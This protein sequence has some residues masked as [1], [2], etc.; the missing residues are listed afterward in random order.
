MEIKESIIVLGASGGIGQALCAQLKKQG[1]QLVV[2]ARNADRLSELASK[3]EVPYLAGDAR[4]LSYVEELA[5]LAQKTY[6]SIT[7]AVNLAGSLLLKPAHT[8]TEEEWK[9]TLETNLTTSFYL[10][11]T[12]AAAMRRAGGSIVLMSSVAARLGLS[13]HEAIAAAKAG[14]EGL[15]ISAAAT[16]SPYKVRVN[17]VA[18]GLIKTPLTEKITQHE[19]S[20]KASL[21][22]HPLNRL[23]EPEDV[24]SAIAWLLNPQQSWVTGQVISVDGGMSHVRVNRVGL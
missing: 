10:L 15:A 16:Y 18:P 5:Q 24:A 9:Q 2:G 4:Q 23:G 19:A 21:A 7:G 6:G 11:R 12:A 3:W 20:A 8:T 17:V 22:M 14:I 1:V 13:N